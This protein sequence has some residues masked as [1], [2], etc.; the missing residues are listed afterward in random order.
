MMKLN[1]YLILLLAIVSC[2]DSVEIKKEYYAGGKLKSISHYSKDSIQQ[3]FFLMEYNSSGELSDSAY[4]DRTG[5]KTGLCY[6]RKDDY[7]TWAYYEKGVRNGKSIVEFDNETKAIQHYKNDS[8]MGVVYWY[9]SKDE[10]FMEVAWYNNRPIIK[11]D[12][13]NIAAHDSFDVVY[14][15]FDGLTKEREFTEKELTSHSYFAVMGD[16]STVPMGYVV[17]DKAGNIIESE[18]VLINA[19][20]TIAQDEP[21]LVNMQGDF[22][23]FGNLS[24]EVIIENPYSKTGYRA[25]FIK[26]VQDK[27]LKVEVNDYS[28]GYNFLIGR[29][30]LYRD[31]TKV[32]DLF[33]YHDFYVKE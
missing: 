3:P 2:N 17:F 9:N 16:S 33:F 20:D 27:S 7:K 5:K 26:P 15:T 32:H 11:K 22:G 8:L 4:Y 14:R 13:F 18:Y 12:I 23:N 28:V 25:T 1:K 10:L 31:T 29:M 30:F 21:L 19:K 6:L 24:W